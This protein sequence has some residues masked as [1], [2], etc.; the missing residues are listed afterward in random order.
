MLRLK[1]ILVFRLFLKSVTY[2]KSLL[3]AVAAVI[4][5]IRRWFPHDNSRFY[6]LKR[7]I[8]F[9]PTGKKSIGQ[10]NKNRE[11]DRPPGKHPVPKDLG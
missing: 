8:S 10:T 5:I 2:P 11:K 9:K 4:A 3:A 1:L 6:W 7:I